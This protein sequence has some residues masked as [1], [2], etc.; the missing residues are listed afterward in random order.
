MT[1]KFAKELAEAKQAWATINEA[2]ERAMESE[3][4]KIRCS[5]EGCWRT[6]ARPYSDG[7]GYLIGWGPPVKDGWHCKAH[8]D[9]LEAVMDGGLDED[10]DEDAV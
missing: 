10:E 2:R 3:K 6:T 4:R 1:R 9:A 7:W 8:G 5:W